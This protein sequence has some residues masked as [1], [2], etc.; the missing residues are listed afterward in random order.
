MAL[1]KSGQ[2]LPQVFQTDKNKK[3]LNASVDQLISEPQQERV[4]GFIG[5]KFALNYSAGDSYV[6]ELSTDRQ[7]YQLEPA[8][9]YKNSSGTVESVTG[10]SDFINR[11]RYYQG[12]TDNHDKLFEQQYYIFWYL[13]I[14][15]SFDLYVKK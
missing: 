9:T 14:L 7:N 4:N 2:L 12:D 11:L 10:Y 15:S 5:R 6:S 13:D 8:V 1:R 3:F